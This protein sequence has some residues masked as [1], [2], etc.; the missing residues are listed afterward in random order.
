MSN[1]FQIILR[2]ANGIARDNYVNTLYFQGGAAQSDEGIADGIHQ[3]YV[4]N[5]L[6]VLGGQIGG[7]TIKG[8]PPGRNLSGPDFEKNYAFDPA[9]GGGNAG[10]AEVALCLSYYAGVN[11][12]RRRGRIFVGPFA[13]GPVGTERPDP[14]LMQLLL[15][16]A[17]DLSSVGGV[18]ALWSQYSRT[19]NDYNDVTNWWVD[20]AWDTMRSRG[21]TPTQRVSGS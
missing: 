14:G 20:N 2:N 18:D 15:D 1:D 12:P 10:P 8:Y 6:G 11:Q 5:L 19:D 16:F 17:S 4:D 9:G 7:M 3:A 13:S 21:A